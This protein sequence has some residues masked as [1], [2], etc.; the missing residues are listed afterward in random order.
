MSVGSNERFRDY[1]SNLNVLPSGLNSFLSLHGDSKHI[2]FAKIELLAVE[3]QLFAGRVHL[4]LDL[5]VHVAGVLVPLLG[6][7][8]EGLLSSNRN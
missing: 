5:A 8:G 4:V 1:Q 7:E 2:S 6:E 3:E